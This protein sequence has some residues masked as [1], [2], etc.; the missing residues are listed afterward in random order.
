MVF[1]VQFGINLDEWVFLKAE[2]ARD[3][4]ALYRFVM[5]IHSKLNEKNRMITY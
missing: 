3:A 5:Q 1:L 2:T 4:T